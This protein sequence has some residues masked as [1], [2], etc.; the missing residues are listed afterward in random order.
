MD[1][2][3]A[4]RDAEIDGIN[5]DLET[6]DIIERLKAWDALYGVEVVE[7]EGDSFTIKFRK[8]PADLLAFAE[9]V[10]EFCPD[11]VFQGSGSPEELADEIAEEGTLLLWW[12]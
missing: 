2:F 5:Y 4:I 9:E 6:D 1:K 7:I 8:L 3:Q 12:D 11:V 10:A